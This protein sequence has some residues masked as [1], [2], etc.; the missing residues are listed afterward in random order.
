MQPARQSYQQTAQMLAT[1]H[2]AKE[3]LTVVMLDPDPSQQEIR[4][5]EVSPATATTRELYPFAFGARPD[6]G[7][8]YP[9]VVLLLSPDE[10]SDVQARRLPLPQGW[11]LDRLQPL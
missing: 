3:H 10:W 9:S 4:L 1:A 8:D 2:R 11:T 7:I 5:L 6:L